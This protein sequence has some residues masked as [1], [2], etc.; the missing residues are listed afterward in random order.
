MNALSNGSAFNT[1]EAKAV[2]VFPIRIWVKLSMPRNC[3]IAKLLL[4]T[5]YVSICI[6]NELQN[7]KIKFGMQ[8]CNRFSGLVSVLYA[9]TRPNIKCV[10]WTSAHELY[11]T[12]GL[13]KQYSKNFSLNTQ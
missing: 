4:F 11:C 5:V 2:K 3:T 12:L 7:F 9:Q 6:A 13:D 10:Y 8:L 1:N